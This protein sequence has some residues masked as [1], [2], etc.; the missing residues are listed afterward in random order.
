MTY[1]SSPSWTKQSSGG[2]EAQC[3][4]V[5]LVAGDVGGL[6]SEQDLH[7]LLAGDRLVQFGGFGDQVGGFCVVHHGDFFAGDDDL[8]GFVPAADAVDDLDLV[9]HLGDFA[10]DLDLGGEGGSGGDG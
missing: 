7:V 1:R 8:A 3:D 4:A 2:G 6:A 10:E 9:E 5:G